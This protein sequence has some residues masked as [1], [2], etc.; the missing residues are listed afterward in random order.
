[1]Y[2]QVANQAQLW[3]DASVVGDTSIMGAD[4]PNPGD[5]VVSF[6]LRQSNSDGDETVRV[7]NVFVGQSFTD[8][9]LSTKENQIEGF[10]FSPNPTSLGYVNIYSR[11]QTAMKVNVFDIL[12]KQVINET[13]RNNRLNVSSLNTGVYIMRVSQDNAF[14]TKKLV[15]N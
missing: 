4:Q 6:A 1:M 11:S 2:D 13:I 12:G 5:T 15:I 9:T 7:D 3:I 10:R 14:V 8:V